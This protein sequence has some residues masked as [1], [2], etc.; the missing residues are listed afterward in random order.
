MGNDRRVKLTMLTRMM[1]IMDMTTMMKPP[2]DI[3]LEE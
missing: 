1:M 3:D 2:S